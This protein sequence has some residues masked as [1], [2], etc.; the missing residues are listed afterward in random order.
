MSNTEYIKENNKNY[1][2]LIMIVCFISGLIAGK[3][4]AS[5]SYSNKQNPIYYISQEEILG[6][7]KKRISDQGEALFYGKT[8]EIFGHIESFIR[9][10]EAKGNQ[11]VLSKGEIVGNNVVSLSKDVH[12]E[13]LEKLKGASKENENK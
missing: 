6:L 13:I 10:Y 9:A 11:V 7:E 3:I 4:Y 2:A 1:A 8:S 12:L 5:V